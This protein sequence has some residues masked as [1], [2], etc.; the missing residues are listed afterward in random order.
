MSNFKRENR[1]LVSK[2]SDLEA[3]LSPAQLEEACDL[4]TYAD[5]YRLQRGALPLECVVVESDWPEY[6]VVW[7]LI[8]GRVAG[9]LSLVH[10]LMTIAKELQQQDPETLEL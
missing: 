8:E 5:A 4:S 10:F 6:E 1:Y 2:L 9:K 7:R 3:A